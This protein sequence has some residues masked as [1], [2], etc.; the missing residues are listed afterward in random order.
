ML[1]WLKK[2]EHYKLK[3]HIKMEKTI[4]KFGDIEIKKQRF[5]QYKRYIST[6]NR[7]INN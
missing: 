7:D 1:I 4:K 2:V 3:I 5:H 6:A